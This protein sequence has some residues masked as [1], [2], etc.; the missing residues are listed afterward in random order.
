MS[1]C[2][3]ESTGNWEC[4]ATGSPQAN[5]CHMEGSALAMKMVSVD[6]VEEGF[7]TGTMVA[8]TLAF[9]LKSHNPVSP[10]MTQILSELPSL[11]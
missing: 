10:N 8:I 6:N 3:G 2:Q 9:S 11:C 5:L 7:S 1:V 4:G